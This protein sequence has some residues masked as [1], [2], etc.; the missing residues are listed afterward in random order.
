MNGLLSSQD[1]GSDELDFSEEI[2]NALT[3]HDLPLLLLSQNQIEAMRALNEITKL[4]Q[5]WDSYGSPPP[6]ILV[7]DLAIDVLTKI[8]HPSLP[9]AS[10]VPTS[11]GGVQLEW[12][13]G[14]R[15]FQLEILVDGSAEYLKIDETGPVEEGSLI[16]TD[17]DKIRSILLGLIPQVR[18]RRVA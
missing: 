3:R 17:Y 4:S 15:R 2:E 10:V 5:N 14:S 18:E 9:A 12:S 1:T 11:G 16:P 7:I 13:I 8:D 6:T